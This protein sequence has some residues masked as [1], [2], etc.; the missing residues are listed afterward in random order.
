MA[1]L[2]PGTEIKVIDESVYVP[3]EPGTIPFILI[4][5][6]ANKTAASGSGIAQGTLSANAEK[7]YLIGSQRELTE[8]FGIPTFQ[9]DSFNTVVQ[10][11]EVSEYGLFAAYSYLGLSNSVYIQRAN[12][13]LN[14]LSGSS[15]APVGDPVN[16]TYWFD[17]ADTSFG[18]F[19]WSEDNQSFVR[20][21]PLKITDSAYISGGIPVTTYGSIGNYAVNATA[22]DN[23]VFYKASDN[24]WYQIG[25]NTW[26]AKW[27]TVRSTATVTSIPN[28]ADLVINGTT[29][30]TLAT[31][32]Q[33]GLVD[34][35]N[36]NGTLTAAGITAAVVNN[37]LEIY[38]TSADITIGA[39][40][41]D[42]LVT[43]LH[44]TEKT[45][46]KPILT[47]GK[48]TQIPLYFDTDSN[49]RPNGS[50]WVK[51]T[52]P[53]QGASFVV[54]KYDSVAGTWTTLQ[55]PLYATNSDAITAYEGSGDASTIVTGVLYVQYD[56]D[57]NSTGSFRIKY[58]EGNVPL[59]VIGTDTTPT[60]PSS[61][62]F[63]ING[64]TVSI[65]TGSV[66]NFISAVS[67]ANIPN[68]SAV[69]ATS[70]AIKIVN[71]VGGEIVLVDGT[72]T[73]LAAAGITGGTYSNWSVL[74]YE[75]KEGEPTADPASGTLWYDTNVSQ[76]DIMQHNGTTWKGYKNIAANSGTDANGVIVAA[77][78]P[79]TQSNGNPL[80]AND[81][82]IDTS[83]IDNFPKIYKYD[84]LNW[85]LVDNT[86]QTSMEG[87]LF[88]DARVNSTGESTG[89]TDVADL[90]DSDYLDPDAP[91]PALY[92][93]GMLLFN[94][95]I[96][97][98]VVREYKPDYLN[99]TDFPNGNERMNTSLPTYKDRWLLHS[100]KKANGALYGG[101][102]AQRASVVQMMQHA[103]VNSNEIRDPSKY[104]N[105]I[106]CPGYP[107]LMDEMVNLNVDR[108]ETA[109]I[110]G[111]MP[112]RLANNTTDIINWV[113]NADQASETGEDGLI[114]NYTYSSIYYPNAYAT[115]L[116][117]AN[118][119]V[120]ASHAMLRTFA[121]NDTVGEQWFA[122]A[123]LRRGILTNIGN[124]G[125][126]GATT[127]EFTPVGLTQGQEDQL[128]SNKVNPLLYIP[129][130]GLVCMGQKTLHPY[131][132]ALDRVNVARLVVYLR[133][134]LDIIT[135]PFIFEPNDKITRS[136]VKGVIDRLMNDLVT[137]R[138]LY[139]YLVVC[140]DSNNT[141][142]R[143]DRNELWIDIA[144]E[145]VKAVEFIYI[146]I[147][148]KATGTIR[149]AQNV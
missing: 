92:P 46:Y 132:S 91:D 75:A 135:R 52:S 3:G 36:A 129:G 73:P 78:R 96:S 130:S 109:F 24:N 12:I 106:A 49:P 41:D 16:G 108:K 29:V 7:L 105:L 84:G 40:S 116:S 128:Y 99:A 112:M 114:S 72:A 74:T 76:I 66:A 31:S 94:T 56:V 8:T 77:S 103:L 121:Y 58:W 15:T 79:T 53:N 4:A 147:R 51:T 21:V 124:I 30:T 55:S 97:G 145:P 67:A 104:F 102:K 119:A 42:T 43:D 59:E 82:W 144:I 23:K 33:T 13:D 50:L 63:T 28:T 142:T 138:A 48:H 17:L 113:T 34:V 139:D 107:E 61:S 44:I 136:E 117:G 62:D 2:S 111:D 57:N 141:P 120:P 65:V 118:V 39:G 37:K 146:P 127:G 71:S 115:S 19:E 5:T 68:I 88:A 126:V 25:S 35:I 93:R 64:T 143:I 95:R 125:Y 6:A 89:S 98:F 1:L 70:G 122:P 20:R 85:N 123:G 80:V 133:R 140:D 101:R 47:Y 60:I 27:A 149:G 9:T 131:T 11:S 18:I 134:Q 69:Q 81:L 22:T 10:G 86:D 32:L 14:Q 148:L 137:R 26:R 38:S 100:G 87:V 110:I 83:D 45:Y 90:L 54:K